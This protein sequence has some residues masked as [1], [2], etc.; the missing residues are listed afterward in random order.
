MDDAITDEEVDVLSTICNDLLRS[1]TR[2]LKEK[3]AKIALDLT[4]TL[5]VKLRKL[6]EIDKKE[7]LEPH[8][9]H[10][11]KLTELNESLRDTLM[12]GITSIAKTLESE[13]ESDANF[14]STLNS[15][16]VNWVNMGW[17]LYSFEYFFK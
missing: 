16:L 8:K 7:E 5:L 9:E 10:I 13:K 6:K 3:A 17:V 1:S 12:N 11:R 2:Q 15:I 4:G 14:M